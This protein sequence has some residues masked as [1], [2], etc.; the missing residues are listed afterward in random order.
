[1]INVDYMK[2]LKQFILTGYIILYPVYLCAMNLSVENPGSF[3]PVVSGARA[4]GL[5]GAFIGLSN[6]ATACATNP[7]GLIQLLRPETSVVYNL[8]VRSEDFT[9]GKYPGTAN[10]I[11][12]TEQ[13]LNFLSFSYP[14]EWINRNW[15][16]SIAYQHLYTF[17]REWFFDIHNYGPIFV[18]HDRYKYKQKGQLSALG[19]SFCAQLTPDLSFGATLNFWDQHLANNG[20]E[21]RYQVNGIMLVD[22]NQYLTSYHQT[23]IFYFNGFNMNFGLLWDIS[24]YLNEKPGIV[25]VGMV[26]KTPFTAE[27]THIIRFSKSDIHTNGELDMPLSFG[28]GLVYN[29]NPY[30]LVTTDIYYTNWHRFIIRDSSGTEMSPVSG[31]NY[32]ESDTSDTFHLRIGAEYLLHTFKPYAVPLRF[33]IF[34]DPAPADKNPDDFYG[35]AFGTGVTREGK[36]SLDAAYQYR[37]GKNV[38]ESFLKQHDFCEDTDEHSFTISAILYIE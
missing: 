1:M 13:N 30:F 2:N 16:F 14:F 4:N 34:Y 27:L 38:G 18:N 8:L 22:D 25:K 32:A 23:Q 10:D 9:F 26:Y 35:F 7:G 37:T 24:E 12:I 11:S 29:V 3:N 36:F 19:F 5:A 20:W 33:G 17:D 6:D 15:V 28:V 21:Q 31:Q